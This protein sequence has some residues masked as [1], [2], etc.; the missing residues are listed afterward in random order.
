MADKEITDYRSLMNLSDDVETYLDRNGVLFKTSVSAIKDFFYNSLFQIETSAPVISTISIY[1]KVEDIRYGSCVTLNSNVSGFPELYYEWYKDYRLVSTDSEYVIPRFNTNHEGSYYLRV[2]NSFGDKSSELFTLSA[3]T[4]D[5]QIK[6]YPPDLISFFVY[7]MDRGNFN[8]GDSIKFSVTVANSDINSFYE[9]YK[10]DV[11]IVTTNSPEYYIEYIE[12]EDIAT[13]FVRSYNS[14]G[15]VD[16]PKIVLTQNVDEQKYFNR[17][18]GFPVKDFINNSIGWNLTEPVTALYNGSVGFASC[19]LSDTKYKEFYV[20]DLT[21]EELNYISTFVSFE[22]SEYISGYSNY[23]VRS[24]FFNSPF[25][26]IVINNTNYDMIVGNYE[27][28]G[29]DLNNIIV[30]SVKLV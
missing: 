16:S 4:D 13:Y 20:E 9:W 1:P 8:V 6:F 29:T 3:L 18:K 12:P 19:D 27:G 5:S 23:K 22:V 11:L 14:F 15:Y 10:D 7:P 24:E 28:T 25:K 26:K 30:Y 2:Y 21:T 17:C